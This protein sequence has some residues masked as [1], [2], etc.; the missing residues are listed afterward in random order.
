MYR[1]NTILDMQNTAFIVPIYDDLYQ[2]KIG[3]CTF[4]PSSYELIDVEGEPWL[5]FHFAN[6]SKPGVSRLSETGILTKFQYKND[7]FGE[8]NAALTSTM[9]LINLQQQGIQEAVKASASYSFMATLSNF[10][11]GTDLK[12][13]QQKFTANNLSGEGGG[14]LLFPN[15]YKDIKQIV[16]RPYTVDTDEMKMIQTNVYN[17]FGVN[18]KILQNTANGDEL[19]AF[20]NGAIEPFSIQFSDVLTKMLFTPLEQARE[21]KIVAAANRLQYMTISEKVSMAQQLGDRGAIMIDEIRDLF[22]LPPLP[23]DAGQQ[24]PIRGEYY[25]VG[26]PKPEAKP[27]D[28]TPE[29]KEP[30]D[31]ED[32]DDSDDEPDPAKEDPN[33]S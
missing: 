22:N 30:D 26:D 9:N 24:A 14:I 10:S 7:L 19:D 5:R 16:T 21:S 23:N 33:A 27:A 4:L 20:F 13:E 25:M 18:D 29:P 6:G 31:P 32:I 28:P 1:L 15:T 3:I 8:D 17:Y 12:T 11:L 2:E